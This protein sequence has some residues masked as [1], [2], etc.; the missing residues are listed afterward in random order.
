MNTIVKTLSVAAAVIP[1]V[2]TALSLVRHPHWI[3]RLWDFPRVQ[4]ATIATAGAAAYAGLFYQRKPIE[5]AMIAAAGA[6]VAWQVYKVFPYTPLVKKQVKNAS[7]ARDRERSISLL[8]SNVQ[9]ENKH[10]DRLIALVREVQP[11]VLLAVETDAGW[12]KALETALASDFEHRVLQPQDNWYG[13]VV[14]SKLP[15]RSK[16]KF[17][18][19]DDI[20]SIHATLKLRSGDEVELHALHPRPPEPLRNQR[21]TPRDAELIVVGRAIEKERKKGPAIVAGD[22]NDVAWSETSQLFVRL[23]GLLDPRVGRGFYN[24]YN[25]RNPMAR[26][27]LDHVFHSNHFKLVDLRRLRSI[28]SDHFPIFAHL[29]YAPE[30]PAEQQSSQKKSGDE[31]QAAER[32]KKEREDKA[33]GKDRPNE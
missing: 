10:Y 30:A 4:M 22:L 2:G 3:F 18:V 21:S 15:M 7:A 16:V 9:M 25:A 1:T 11:D 31:K 32:L 24:S 13:M 6:S 23:S 28:G 29:F 8:M 17:L 20:P 26:F 5:T 33:T 19:Q 14:F 12:T 27:P